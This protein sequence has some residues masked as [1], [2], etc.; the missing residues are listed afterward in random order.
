[1][2]FFKFAHEI[3]QTSHKDPCILE[4][5]FT[6][7]LSGDDLGRACL[8]YLIGKALKIKLNPLGVFQLQNGILRH[9]SSGNI[10]LLK[11]YLFLLENFNQESLVNTSVPWALGQCILLGNEELGQTFSF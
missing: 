3:S 7:T 6:K 11:N 9:G 10:L 5:R 4:V 1:M 2:Q 8:N